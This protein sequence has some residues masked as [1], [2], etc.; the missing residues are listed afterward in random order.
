MQILHSLTT[1]QAK[2]YDHYKL[3]SGDPSYNLSFL[4]KITGQLD[5]AR[6]KSIF[7]IIYNTLDILSVDFIESNNKIFQRYIQERKYIPQLIIKEH[8]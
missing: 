8:S 2:L 7:E 4:Y 5:I 3:Y 1:N 6:L